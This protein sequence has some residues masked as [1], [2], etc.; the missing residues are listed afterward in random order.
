MVYITNI[1]YTVLDCWRLLENIH[2]LIAGAWNSSD[3]QPLSTFSI[4][5]RR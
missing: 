3:P 4:G 1:Y 2:D 5:R